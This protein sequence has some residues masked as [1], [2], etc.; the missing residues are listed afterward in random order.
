MQAWLFQAT[1]D[2]K[3]R[4]ELKAMLGDYWRVATNFH[5]L[6]QGDVAILWQAGPEAGIYA[7]AELADDPG[8]TKK[9]EWQVD[10][11]Y[12][13]LLR[14]PVLKSELLDHP[15]LKDLQVLRNPH[16]G[17]AMTVTEEQWRALSELIC[18]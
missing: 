12:R 4:S 1:D 17:N 8:E 7:V 11:R 5:N 6:R 13:G 3:L 2:Y 16:T 9:G 15:V 10:I 14:R 18:D